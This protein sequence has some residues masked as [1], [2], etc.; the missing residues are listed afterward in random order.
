M[1]SPF[2]M[3]LLGHTEM[4]YLL[5]HWDKWIKL[6]AGR[7]EQPWSSGCPESLP[8]GWRDQAYEIP[9]SQPPPHPSVC[10]G[11]PYGKP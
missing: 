5:S 9:L 10:H 3:S 4:L 8:E 7:N 2:K 11:A 1:F 6:L